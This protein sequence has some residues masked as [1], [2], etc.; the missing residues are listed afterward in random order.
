MTAI[1][2]AD[3]RHGTRAG[4]LAGCRC[5]PC[6]TAHNRYTKAY[7][8]N[9]EERGTPIRV[10]ATPAAQ[11]ITHL[12][13]HMSLSAIA[14]AAGLSESAI[15]DIARGHRATIQ[16]NTH[17][18]ILNVTTPPDHGNHRR[19]PVGTLRRL[20][21]LQVLGWSYQ[22]ISHHSGISAE[23]LSDIANRPPVMVEKQT[24]DAITRAYEQLSTSTPVPRSPQHA[25]GITRAR[26]HAQAQGW[27]P[28]DAWIDPDTDAAPTTRT[29]AD[30]AA[31]RLADL[32][33]MA[34]AGEHYERAAARLGL[35]TRSLLAWCYRNGHHDLARALGA[36]ERRTNFMTG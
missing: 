3:H 35:T 24:A 34:S 2:P 1:T 5:H 21:A 4:Y 22:T 7:K 20:Q 11:H 26:A 33:L 15:F 32:Q 14:A 10:D 27:L 8:A 31:D 18:A 19:S 9:R 16:P 25:G 17:A 13:Q 6:A 28:P 23:Y 36:P 30:I 29:L 12:R